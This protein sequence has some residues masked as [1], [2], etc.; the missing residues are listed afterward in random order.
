[1]NVPQ[2]SSA[3][4][5]PSR[6][7]RGRR[8]RARLRPA[9]AAALAQALALAPLA[10]CGEDLDA[11]S[12]APACAPVGLLAEAADYSD[13]GPGP[14]QDLSRL[15]AQ[16]SIRGVTG[17]CSSAAH[18]TQLHTVVRVQLA[19]NRGP[20]AP[21]SSLA[22]PYF[23]AVLRDG[24]VLSKQSLVAIAEFPDNGD[25]VALQTDPVAFDLPV[26]RTHPGTSY[27]IEVGFQLT[28]A[29]LAYNRA[30]LPR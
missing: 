2:T 17:H 11:D 23:I 7:R 12:F 29:Q 13:Y 22:V 30:H 4:R 5:S 14:V 20:V 9:V 28:P 26:S 6:P 18:G 27:R 1:M 15:V 16:G 3:S 21:G 25:R 19:I 8:C 10:G 24:A